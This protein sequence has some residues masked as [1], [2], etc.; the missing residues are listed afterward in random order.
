MNQLVADP[1]TSICCAAVGYRLDANYKPV[2]ADTS[3][4][5]G[6]RMTSNSSISLTGMTPN[7]TPA[8]SATIMSANNA[9]S[10]YAMLRRA[11]Q[12][13]GGLLCINCAGSLAL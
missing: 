12:S 3:T 4:T 5:S 13:A 6:P 2:A 7:T 10:R 8:S 1:E 9:M 11:W